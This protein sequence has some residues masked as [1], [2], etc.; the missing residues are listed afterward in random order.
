MKKFC[1]F[2]LAALTFVACNT[3][4]PVQPDNKELLGTWRVDSINTYGDS[5][6]QTITFNETELIY[7]QGPEG[8]ES[9]P[10]NN[11]ELGYKIEN[12]MLCI[13]REDPMPFEYKTS[14]SVQGEHLSIDKFSTD[15]LYFRKLNLIKGGTKY[16]PSESYVPS[17]EYEGVWES[18]YYAEQNLFVITADSMF[19]IYGDGSIHFPCRYRI[20]SEGM[21]ELERTYFP[22]DYISYKA[23]V[24]IYFNKDSLLV[25]EKYVL[26]AA[27]CYPPEFLNLVLKRK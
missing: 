19:F 14:Y 27:G 12:G 7:F 4:N 10:G 24:P 6:N 18:P 15:G 2:I 21:I 13:F 5:L 25:I 22:E 26:S 16:Q 11:T 17:N 8:D 1:L 3:N 23:E 9:W 20:I